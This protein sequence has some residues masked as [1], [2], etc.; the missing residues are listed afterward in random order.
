[1]GPFSLLIVQKMEF[2]FL[3]NFLSIKLILSTF[4]QFDVEVFFNEDSDENVKD[5]QVGDR[6]IYN[7]VNVPKTILILGRHFVFSSRINPIKS[8]KRF[9]FIK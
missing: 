1:M 6:E 4:L 7:V 8:S 9:L 5:N 3:S 2:I